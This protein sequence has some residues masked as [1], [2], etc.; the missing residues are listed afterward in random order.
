[1]NTEK[2]K[3]VTVYAEATPNPASMKFVL[4]N[5][6]LQEGSVEY[7]NPGQTGNSPLAKQLFG[8][9]GISSVFITANFITLT[10]NSDVDW[11]ELIPI[12]REYI[13]NYFQ[14]DEPVFTG[15][16]EQVADARIERT[17]TSSA[18]ESKII[19]TL[20][21]YVK[22]AVEQDGGAIHFKSFEEG[23]VTVVMKGSC[24]GCPSST[25]TLKSGIENLLKQLIPE[26]TEVV[27][28]AD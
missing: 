26:V 19:E 22:P 24:S 1:M 27:A 11:Y 5:Y 16:T 7:T 2:M 15:P 28:V 14:N 10:K 23:V 21:E 4:N 12:L 6:I 18:L 25:L 20:D 3:L 9:S 17:K 8:F 13:K